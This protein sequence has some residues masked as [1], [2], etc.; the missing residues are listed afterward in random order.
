MNNHNKFW[1][2]VSLLVVFAAGVAAGIL[3]DNYILDKRVKQRK[4]KRNA[5]RF[6]TLEMMAEE[7]KLTPE[8]EEQ[9]RD[10]FR[11]NDERIKSLRT[12]IH[13]KFSRMR[14]Q[15]K[16]EIKSVLS[17]DQKTKFDAIIEKYVSQM[18][19]EMEERKKHL[20]RQKKGEGEK[21]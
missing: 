6:P 8:Q 2:A 20:E 7:L 10:I 11:N 12:E 18:R 19:K 4:E 9:I 16:G 1:I 17:E 3:I 13:E 15:L 21:K 5:A 14:S